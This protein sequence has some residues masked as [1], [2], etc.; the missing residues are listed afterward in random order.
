M[1]PTVRSLYRSACFSTRPSCGLFPGC[2]ML[3]TR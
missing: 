1:I 2:A 3:S